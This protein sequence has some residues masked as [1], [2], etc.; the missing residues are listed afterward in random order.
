[1]DSV[2]DCSGVGGGDVGIEME[3]MEMVRV[4]MA[5]VVMRLRTA[6]G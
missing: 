2:D 4:I 6:P 5:R 1:M 3:L